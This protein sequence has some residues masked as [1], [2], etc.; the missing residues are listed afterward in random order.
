M[1]GLGHEGVDVSTC[2]VPTVR[3]IEDG[4]NAY[5]LNL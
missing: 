3:A 5:A 1:I 4:D 2:T